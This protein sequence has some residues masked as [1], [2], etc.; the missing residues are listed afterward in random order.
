MMSI[1]VEDLLDLRDSLKGRSYNDVV[2]NSQ[3]THNTAVNI[4][5]SEGECFVEGV[6]VKNPDHGLFKLAKV[7]KWS[8][9]CSEDSPFTLLC[10]MGSFSILFELNKEEVYELVFRG[11]TNFEEV[12]DTLDAI[13]S[14]ICR[15]PEFDIQI[16]LTPK[17][18]KLTS[19]IEQQFDDSVRKIAREYT[20]FLED[21]NNRARFRRVPI[22]AQ[23]EIYLT[24]E[25][26]G[27]SLFLPENAAIYACKHGDY[28]TSSPVMQRVEVYLWNKDSCDHLI[29]KAKQHYD[30]VLLG[31]KVSI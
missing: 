16:A 11:D 13:S 4:T 5:L 22:P 14:C 23:Y 20:E 29:D 17:D 1:K 18:Q 15:T 12:F 9:G 31:W 7:L 27:V 26:C 28:F 2:D 30:A 6:L 25:G 10:D 19:S 3:V 8:L 24:R 21:T